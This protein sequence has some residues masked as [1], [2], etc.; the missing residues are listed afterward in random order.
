MGGGGDGGLVF[1][2]ASV[3]RNYHLVIWCILWYG[4][5]LVHGYERDKHSS[6]IALERVL[7]IGQYRFRTCMD[8]AANRERHE[9]TRREQSREDRPKHVDILKHLYQNWIQ[10][11]LGSGRIRRQCPYKW[12][13]CPRCPKSMMPWQHICNFLPTMIFVYNNPDIMHC[14]TPRYAGGR[15]DVNKAP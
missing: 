8:Q 5:E 10:G 6:G 4:M 1:L 9:P 15:K 14:P 13:V 11:P 12:E 2:Y 3:G 7:Y